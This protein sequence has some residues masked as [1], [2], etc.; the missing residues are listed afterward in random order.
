MGSGRRVLGNDP[1]Q[2]GAAERTSATT[3]ASRSPAPPPEETAAP[4]AA[5]VVPPGESPGRGARAKRAAGARGTRASRAPGA[6]PGSPT[7][8]GAGTPP[9]GERGAP[10]RPPAPKTPR[11]PGLTT[12]AIPEE[13][14]AASPP[15]RSGSVPPAAA[16]APPA[17]VS[18]TAPPPV[19]LAASVVPEP[20]A[21]PGE[22][23]PEH[24]EAATES[25]RGPLAEPEPRAPGSREAPVPTLTW[26]P[27]GGAE[28]APATEPDR[29][30]GAVAAGA[31][32]A[33]VDVLREAPGLI[34]EAWS[35]IEAAVRAIR[36][37]LG[38]SGGEQLDVFGRD[39]RLSEAV[40][41]LLDFLYSRWFRV[42]VEGAGHVPAGGALLVA[43]HAGALP[44]DGPMLH[45]ALRRERPDLP[46]S[47]WL[48]EDQVFYAPLLG[49]LFNRLGAVRA[50][51]DSATRLL[52]EGRPILIFPEGIQGIGKPFRDRYRLQR[53][54]RGG[55]VKL[56]LR[57][58]R[59]ILP[60]AIMGA[61]E[62]L[63]L[64]GKLP[65]GLFGVPYVPVTPLGPLPLP[66]KWRIRI[67]EPIQVP[68][69]AKE[70][71]LSVVE[72]LVEATRSTIEHM[73]RLLLGARGGVFL[74]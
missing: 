24:G 41:P 43:N 2:R 28:A 34:A 20:A 52:G 60:V 15:V 64:L 42:E 61:E 23:V 38:T 27:L 7:E 63:P 56:A 74:G 12:R 25:L 31:G 18:G 16:D 44:L 59:P 73:L 6:R 19:P 32:A 13:G 68:P 35:A 29:L 58:R 11:A 53:F 22:P 10:L 14:V 36:A 65:G 4:G 47:R 69:G 37:G 51:P 40:A 33:L 46:D 17:P 9:A 45:E 5:S 1:F 49:T 30:G 55:F 72:S 8:P 48:A 3:P 26:T 71:D 70:T 21:P 62:T 54:G 57:T 50:S 39:A 67:G 66:A